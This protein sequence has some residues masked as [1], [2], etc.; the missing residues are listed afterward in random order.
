VLKKKVTW[1]CSTCCDSSAIWKRN[2]TVYG[3]VVSEAA[4]YQNLCYLSWHW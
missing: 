3:C 2:F 4:V 1:A